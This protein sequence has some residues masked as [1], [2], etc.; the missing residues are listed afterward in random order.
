MPSDK[1]SLALSPSSDPMFGSRLGRWKRWCES[2]DATQTRRGRDQRSPTTPF[3]LVSFILNS[4]SSSHVLTIFGRF[5]VVFSH[6]V[7]TRV[8]HAVCT[9]CACAVGLS[10]FHD[11]R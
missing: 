3:R 7:R 4:G 2:S 10:M 8:E 5:R 1:T 9:Y 11:G 6:I